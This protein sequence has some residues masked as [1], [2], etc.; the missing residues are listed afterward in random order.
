MTVLAVRERR[1]TTYVLLD[2]PEVE[3]SILP[4]FEDATDFFDYEVPG[5]EAQM[6]EIAETALILHELWSSEGAVAPPG[7]LLREQIVPGTYL[8]VERP[9]YQ[10]VVAFQQLFNSF[11]TR[12]CSSFTP[13]PYHEPPAPVEEPPVPAPPTPPA[14][15]A[16]PP[17]PGSGTP[18]PTPPLSKGGEGATTVKA[19]GT[20][21]ATTTTGG[22]RNG[23]LFAGVAGALLLGGILYLRS[24]R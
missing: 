21:G 11:D 9:F 13:E 7:P 15:E 17:A 10:N 18:A 3:G 24:R 22:S 6:A 5:C 12:S 1:G 20:A 2:R 16:R 19:P 4:D 23:L 8:V 14:P